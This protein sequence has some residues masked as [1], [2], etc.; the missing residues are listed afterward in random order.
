MLQKIFAILNERLV[1]GIIF[2]IIAGVGTYFIVPKIQDA[3][4]KRKIIEEEKVK[5]IGDFIKNNEKINSQLNNIQTMLEIFYK[6]FRDD[7]KIRFDIEIFNKE[8]GKLRVNINDRYLEFDTYAWWWYWSLFK[9]TDAK[10]LIERDKLDTLKR[11]LTEYGQNIDESMRILSPLWDL[12]VRKKQR[13]GEETNQTLKES[14]SKLN[15]LRESRD[16][17]IDEIVK[18]YSYK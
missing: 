6:D 12:L 16:K 7:P 15:R 14:R 3:N 5:M 1:A 11:H 4:L 8:K 13:P 10:I 9:N 18:L 2:M 17:I